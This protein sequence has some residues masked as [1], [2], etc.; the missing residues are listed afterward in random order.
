ME[1]FQTLAHQVLGSH[2]SSEGIAQLRIA[3]ARDILRGFLPDPDNQSI[4]PIDTER[5][6][7]VREAYIEEIA[8]RFE[9]NSPNLFTS[10]WV[11][12]EQNAIF[13]GE[14]NALE[15][16]GIALELL[17]ANIYR[18]ILRA[19]SGAIDSVTEATI[20]NLGA[21]HNEGLQNAYNDKAKNYAN[22]ILTHMV[23]FVER[24]CDL[25]FGRQPAPWLDFKYF[26][27]IDEPFVDSDWDGTRRNEFPLP[28][29]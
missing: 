7:E 17:A 23:Q 1:N 11:G 3:T 9:G 2:N 26:N 18:G 29:R 27:N 14:N 19:K 25:G 12:R 21:W 10:L 22:S 4:L 16:E 24:D 5:L 15:D 13:E 20:F 6:D 8:S 28:A